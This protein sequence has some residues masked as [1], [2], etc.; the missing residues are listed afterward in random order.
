M[1]TTFPITEITTTLVYKSKDATDACQEA[2]KLE[3]STETKTEK[4]ASSRIWAYGL[5]L[6]AWTAV[7]GMLLWAI[8]ALCRED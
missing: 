4:S 2:C 3:T 5:Q 8:V 1:E 7:L 6:T